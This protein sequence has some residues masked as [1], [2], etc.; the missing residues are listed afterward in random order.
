MKKTAR[1]L[2]VAERYYRLRCKDTGRYVCLNEDGDLALCAKKKQADQFAGDLL[3]F[4]TPVAEVMFSS[5]FLE[6]PVP[7][8]ELEFS[9]MHEV[10]KYVQ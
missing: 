2:G 7:T 1:A 5:E 4:T 10:I 8:D 6:V 9:R 3:E